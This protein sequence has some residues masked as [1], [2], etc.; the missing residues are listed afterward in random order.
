MRAKKISKPKPVKKAAVSKPDPEPKLDVGLDLEIQLAPEIEQEMELEAKLGKAKYRKLCQARAKTQK[1]A[2]KEQKAREAPI[3]RLLDLMQGLGDFWPDVATEGIR[4]GIACLPQKYL[5]LVRKAV[6][7]RQKE[8]NREAPLRKRGRPGASEDFSI[9]F[10]WLQVAWWKWVQK[11][12]WRE[13]VS[14]KR[15]PCE[16]ADNT[17][18]SRYILNR[19]V[20]DLAGLVRS[21]LR[22][23]GV[24]SGRQRLVEPNGHDA[25]LQNEIEKT[26][27]NYLG[28]NRV[29]YALRFK[30]GFPLDRD[31]DLNR[32]IAQK[33]YFPGSRLPL[34]KKIVSDAEQLA[35]ELFR[36][37]TGKEPLE[38][39][40]KEHR[41]RFFSKTPKPQA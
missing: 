10:S 32:H 40:L 21:T 9:R 16:D 34:N 38:K 12:T 22:N 29:H 5:D 36:K 18:A 1:K 41:R 33:L 24:P 19:Q 37:G 30:F 15:M 31:E 7:Q 11:K 28:A 35:K 6:R 4:Q 27:N 17:R 39:A 3:S 2:L 23:F 8:I 20:D 26:L 13:I 14:K 25:P